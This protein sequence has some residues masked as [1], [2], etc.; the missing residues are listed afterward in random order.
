MGGWWYGVVD[1]RTKSKKEKQEM[2]IGRI[3]G[4]VGR[5]NQIESRLTA[6]L[7]SVP[8]PAVALSL[9]LSLSL[10]AIVILIV[11]NVS[12]ASLLT[13]EQRKRSFGA[14]FRLDRLSDDGLT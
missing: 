2:R 8:K 9:S 10:L 12:Q 11:I 7:E 6:R 4:S 1:V 5:S 14:F 13:Y 3:D